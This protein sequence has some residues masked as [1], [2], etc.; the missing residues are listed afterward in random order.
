MLSVSSCWPYWFRGVAAPA[1]QEA[2][3]ASTVS[4][5]FE[6]LKCNR[7]HALSRFEIVA[8]TSSEKMRG[9]DLSDVGST[10]DAEWLTS[11]LEREVEVDGNKHKSPWKGDDEQLAKLTEWL[12]KL[13]E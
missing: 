1:S 11:F 2:A 10:R 8:T 6:E 5:L 13:V 7:C 12:A 3:D 9:P 4:P